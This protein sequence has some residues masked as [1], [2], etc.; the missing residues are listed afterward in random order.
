VEI[1]CSQANIALNEFIA[2]R[3]EKIRRAVRRLISL[4]DNFLT[5]ERL[6]FH[7]SKTQ[8]EPLDLRELAS[9]AVKNWVHFLHSP[10]QLRLEL[11]DKP[12]PVCADRVMLSLALSNLIDNAL[13]Y[14]PLGSPITLRVGITHGDAW[15][16]VQ[17]HGSG[18][19]ADQITHVFD[20][21]YRGDDA[22][23]APGA[24][25]GLHLV[26]TIARSQGGDVELESKLGKGSRFR[27]RLRL[28]A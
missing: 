17:D 10:G 15:I 28:E 1:A 23:K 13:K 9:E 20:K 3:Q 18:L 25:L 5:H 19:S 11:G 4:M 26:R 27:M 21:F 8:S 24:G 16:E 6:D 12:V 14:S 7:D 22:Q 2:P